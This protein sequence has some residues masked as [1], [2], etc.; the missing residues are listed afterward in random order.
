MC[1]LDEYIWSPKD[2]N[3]CNILKRDCEELAQI[4]IHEFLF[5]S[6]GH[7]TEPKYI[8]KEFTK[9]RINNSSEKN[10]NTL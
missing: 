2:I 4:Q 6:N 8:V 5:G 3:L 9:R 10:I 7:I 1:D